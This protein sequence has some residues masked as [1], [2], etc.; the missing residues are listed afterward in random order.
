V[1][2]YFIAPIDRCFELVGLLRLNWH[3]LSG[4]E[5]VWKKIQDYFEKLK[6]ENRGRDFPANRELVHA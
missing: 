4:G 3:G 2:I 5:K 6:S 1:K